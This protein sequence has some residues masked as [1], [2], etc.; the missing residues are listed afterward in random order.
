MSVNDIRWEEINP[1]RFYTLQA[2]VF[3]GIR[4]LLYPNSVVKYVCAP[5]RPAARPRPTAR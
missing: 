3:M 4:A 1:A 2:T 5:R